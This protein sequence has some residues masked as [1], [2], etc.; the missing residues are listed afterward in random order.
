M[1][2]KEFLLLVRQSILI[3]KKKY[4]N[5]N[6]MKE[7]LMI[8]FRQFQLTFYFFLKFLFATIPLIVFVGL[9][10]YFNFI[11]IQYFKGFYFLLESFLVFSLFYFYRRYVGL[12]A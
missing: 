10:A 5:E 8:S 6:Q 9:I 2:I 1:Y 7:L 11:D 12:K 4:N 3:F